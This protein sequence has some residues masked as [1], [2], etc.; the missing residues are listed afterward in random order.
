MIDT[1]AVTGITGHSGTYFLH[2]LIRNN[3]SGLVRCLVRESSDTT[4]LDQSGLNVEKIYGDANDI[5]ALRKL[6]HGADVVLH[7]ANIHYSV[8]ITKVCIVEN[9]PKIIL[10][11]TTGIYSKYKSASN[12]YKQIETEIGNLIDNQNLEMIILRPTMI[13]GDMC[14][15]NIHKFIKMVDHLPVMPEI[16]HGTGKIQP[17]NARDLG[18]AYLQVCMAE[19]LPENDYILSGSSEISLHELFDLIGKDL[20]KKT[21]HLSVPMSV[22]TLGA[23]FLKIVSGGKIDYLERVLRM[24]EDRSFDHDKATKDFDYFPEP[25]NIGLKREV[26]RYQS[27]KTK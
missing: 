17:V 21:R 19:N 4:A 16:N 13:F 3:Y 20:G 6:V 1:I 24:G 23:K 26:E 2:E 7:I 18:K 11:H 22:G 25:F 14:D 10:V 8:P 12:E 27:R 5:H 15:H 9:V